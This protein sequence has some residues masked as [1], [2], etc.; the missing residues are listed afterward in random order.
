MRCQNL[1]PVETWKAKA[2]PTRETRSR[3][4]SPSTGKALQSSDA[5]RVTTDT[6]VGLP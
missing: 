4:S 3:M 2:V 1:S 5:P 6:I